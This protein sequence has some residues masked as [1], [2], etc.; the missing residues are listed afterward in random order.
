MIISPYMV[1]IKM[2]QNTMIINMFY[3][4]F[5]RNISLKN[6]IMIIALKFILI[7]Y[8]LIKMNINI[9]TQIVQF[10]LTIMGIQRQVVKQKKI[11]VI[12]NIAMLNFLI[13]LILVIVKIVIMILVLINLKVNLLKNILKK[14]ATVF[15]SQSNNI[16][17][18]VILLILNKHQ[19][20]IQ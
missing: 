8:T 1:W 13:V 4:S 10:V 11:I 14:F 7:K 16:F 9:M 19:L 20:N 12:V 3:Q 2:F 18:M 17:M 6:F 5:M 15:T